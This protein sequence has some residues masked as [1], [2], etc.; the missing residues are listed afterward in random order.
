MA[1][2]KHG[3]LSLGCHQRV[4][5]KFNTRCFSGVYTRMHT[6]RPSPTITTKCHNM[7]NGRVGHWDVTEVL[8]LSLLEAATIRAVAGDEPSEIERYFVAMIGE[9]QS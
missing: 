6:D 4:N 3:D 7:S 8:G 1:E 2:T 5:R 9:F